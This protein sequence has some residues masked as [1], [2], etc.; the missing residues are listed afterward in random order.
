MQIASASVAGLTL[1]FIVS[2]LGAVFTCDAV[3]SAV[4]A[5]AISSVCPSHA[6]F[7]AGTYNPIQ[8]V[9]FMNA[10]KLNPIKRD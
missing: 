5:T 9:V 7:V 1:R 8:W 2:H 3:L 10:C 6:C 4:Y